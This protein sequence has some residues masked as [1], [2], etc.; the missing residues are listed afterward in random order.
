MCVIDAGRGIGR[1]AAGT[2]MVRRVYRSTACF[3]MISAGIGVEDWGGRGSLR[4]YVTGL[5][6]G[7][8]LCLIMDSLRMGWGYATR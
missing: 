7:G 1:Q 3:M 2:M 4:G 6:T 8:C 5:P